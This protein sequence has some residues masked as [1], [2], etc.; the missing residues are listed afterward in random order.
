MYENFKEILKKIVPKQ[1]LFRYEEIIRIPY[2]L[3]YSGNKKKCNICKQGLR[4]FIETP[5]QKELCPHCG[6][7]SRTRRLNDLLENKY[8]LTGTVLHFSPARCLY[9]RLKKNTAIKYYPSD[10]ENEFIADY[11]FDITDIHMAD[12]TLD[13]IICYHILEHILNDVKAIQEL[14]RVL[15]PG[16]IM[17]IQTPFKE[18]TI[19]ED[20]KIVLPE[21]RL[22]HFGQDDHVRIYSVLGLENRLKAINFT[23]IHRMQFETLDKK[24]ELHGLQ[25]K[26]TIIEVTK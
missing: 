6:S 23:N 18:G 20:P 5:T 1:F 4:K 14:Y 13:F 24:S 17:L 9:R 11:R 16:G 26:E 19:Y 25:E 7:L 21:D 22:I 12:N 8:E 2:G 3:L 15:K 10:Y